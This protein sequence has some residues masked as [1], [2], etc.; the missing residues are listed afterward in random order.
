[1][2]EIPDRRIW[3]EG[4]PGVF[5]CRNCGDWYNS[6]RVDCPLV[7]EET[8]VSKDVTDIPYSEPQPGDI[9]Y[10]REAEAR[11]LMLASLKGLMK[12]CGEIAEEHGFH[13]NKDNP[14]RLLMLMV[15]E[16]SEAH[17]DLRNGRDVHE[18]YY[19]DKP[20]GSK[21]PC[22]FGV[23][24]ADCIIRIMDAAAQLEIDLP[25]MILEKMEYNRSRPYLHGRKF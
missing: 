14:D 2:T 6:H 8:H 12:I 3:V 9:N 7:R 25:S 21:K 11:K 16:L 13:V 20:D 18:V 1:M 5:R 19:E 15:G 23:E 4:S 24:L 22:G 17:E 10:D